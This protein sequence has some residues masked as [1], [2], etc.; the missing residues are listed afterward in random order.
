MNRTRL[1]LA[2]FLL[3]SYGAGQNMPARVAE[4]EQLQVKREGSD[5][6]I[7]VILTGAVQPSVETA[8]NPDRLVLILPGTLSDAKQ[9][10]YPLGTDGV[11]GVRVGLNSANPPV[12]RVVVDLDSALPY[13]LSTEGTHVVLRV[14][15]AEA[16]HVRHDGAVPAASTP[17]VGVFR[18]KP[19]APAAE[20]MASAPASVPVPPQLPPINFAEKQPATAQP[21]DGTTAT[22][23]APSSTHPKF[24]SLQQGTVFPGAGTPG[25]GSVPET[26]SVIPGSSPSVASVT[27]GNST[28]GSPRAAAQ[29]PAPPL[30]VTL[31][32]ANGSNATAS[33]GAS[34]TP[35]SSTAVITTGGSSGPVVTTPSAATAKVTASI[36]AGAAV[37][38]VPSEASSSTTR[39]EAVTEVQQLQVKRD[40]S[41]VDIEVALTGQVKAS[42]DRATSPERV[43]LTLPA[44]TSDARQKTYPVHANG[45]QSVRV[46]LNSAN[47]PVTRVVVEL[48]KERPYNLSFAGN[49]VILHIG[50]PKVL[51][52]LASASARPPTPP[53]APDLKAEAT[54]LI[55]TPKAQGTIPVAVAD[56]ATSTVPAN[57]SGAASAI[58]S[59]KATPVQ[60]TTSSAGA[61]N[62]ITKVISAT[63]TPATTTAA[64]TTN[65]PPSATVANPLGLPATA[66][67]TT[68]STTA[69]A[70]STPSASQGATVANPLGLPANTATASTTSPGTTATASAPPGATVSNPFGLAPGEKLPTAES[71]E[72]ATD[73]GATNDVSTMVSADAVPETATVSASAGST[74][75]AASATTTA[76]KPATTLMAKAT[77]PEIPA[78][79]ALRA[80]HPDF[81]TTFRVKYVAEGVAY[82]DGGRGAGLSEGMKLVVRET[83]TGTVVAAATGSDEHIVA[84]LEVKSVAEASAVTDIHTPN[85]D[86]KPGDLA[87]LSAQD[88]Q[89]LVQQSTLSSTRKY[90]TV[91]SFTEDDTLDEEARAQIPKPPL[92]SINRAR[93][94]F[95]FDYIGTQFHGASGGSNSNIGLIARLDMTRI[96][97]TYWNASGYWRGQLNANSYQGTQT[98]QDVIN[99]TYHLAMTYDNP[100]SAW[101]AGFG[102]MYLPWAT[103]L[104]TIDGGYFGRR[105]GHG[106]TVG[107]FAGST[108]DPSSYSYNPDRR[109][110]GVFVNFEGGSYDD[111]RF[112]STSG[113][114]I[115]TIKWQIDRPFVF[116]ENG[117]SYKRYVSVYDSLQADSPAGNTVA[118]APG[119]G[120]GRNF[121][122]V[123]FQPHERIELDAN[124]NYFRDVPTFDPNL[125]STTLLDKYLFQ[126]F[127]AGMRLEVIKQLWLYAQLGRSSRSG[128]PTAS[129]NEL[130]GVTLGRVPWV[131][132]RADAHYSRFNSSF[133]SG[134]YESVSL[135]R[136]LS[137]S[138]RLEVLG[139]KQ[140]FSSAYSSNSNTHYVTSN[141][142]MNMGLHYFF[143]GGYT[144]SRGVI[145]NY[146]Q[147]MFTLGYRFDTRQK[148]GQ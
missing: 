134:Y 95:G 117:V 10:R 91:I 97:G 145:Q 55:L 111:F 112:T 70:T 17:L 66:T 136:S 37:Q 20:T 96:G 104:D 59:A 126:G 57:P 118:T 83:P 90:P 106:S 116:F 51:T 1:F 80:T 5:V 45:V 140:N 85:R 43:V 32:S 54:K 6:K 48:D 84:E 135:S 35:T 88:E 107:V 56:P 47:P 74:T 87:Y 2:L 52:N 71:A 123:R 39:S 60:P 73:I 30:I 38:P 133:G 113:I 148:G 82:L 131:K 58:L 100:H 69:S 14:Q 46:G 63:V 3:G 147:W 33:A 28:S 86:V 64:T 61:P 77:P 67:S 115:S 36:P 12:T 4:V 138:F 22:A 130:Y 98:L 27:P 9:K 127:S 114:G 146:D 143:Q 89:S 121:L 142:E 68:S 49:N 94:R 65:A 132:I 31:G 103:S 13:A 119:A 129:L 110:G 15:T 101:V 62:V 76:A 102:R 109:I 44:T 139:G 75:A 34:S 19:Q 26:Q 125:I 99:R 141:L 93:G 78:V 137:D 8:T 29:T 105:M 79:L 144:F 124:Y 108:P 7:E 50:T 53:V 42:V 120:I 40:G 81:R 72:E 128:D 23:S 21:P 24:G 122:T 41:D 25:S 18:R 92:P 11:E 16:A